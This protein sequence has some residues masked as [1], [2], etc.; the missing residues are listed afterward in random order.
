MIGGCWSGDTNAETGDCIEKISHYHPQRLETPAQ[1]RFLKH[2]ATDIT[3][4]AA[5]CINPSETEL[6]QMKIE[7]K[8]K[9]KNKILFFIYNQFLKYTNK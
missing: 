8:S 2:E 4:V 7:E 5:L 1:M 3:P 9:V 6:E